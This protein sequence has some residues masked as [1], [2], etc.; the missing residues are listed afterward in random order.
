MAAPFDEAEEDCPAALDG[1]FALVDGESLRW[2]PAEDDDSD[3]VA[4]EA[5]RPYDSGLEPSV[6]EP[7]RVLAP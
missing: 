7:A 4:P 3:A 6:S 5:C 1:E 2:R